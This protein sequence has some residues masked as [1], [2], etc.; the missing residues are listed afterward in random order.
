MIENLVEPVRILGVCS[1]PRRA[2]TLY[3][4]QAALKEAEKVPGVQTTLLH[5]RGKD[6]VKPCL[7]CDY[8][9]RN[10]MRCAEK[11][12]MN[13]L[14]DSLLEYDAFLF[15]TP[16]YMGT[17]NAQMKAFLD[18]L[19]PI[20]VR[21]QALTGKVGGV[22]AV[23]G[24]RAGGHEPAILDIVS[25][26]MTFGIYP[27]GG[28][29]GGNLGACVWSHDK[30]RAFDESVD[31]EG[32]RIVRALALKVAGTASWLRQARQTLGSTPAGSDSLALNPVIEAGL[33][34]EDQA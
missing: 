8:C 15:A 32:L 21:A 5:L 3:C 33:K 18:R 4:L 26:L 2:S 10:T 19:R 30:A 31:E 1:S 28:L 7:H 27:V 6:I 20:W 24:D 17:M 11:D 9:V 12:I 16:V 29:H 34:A 22:I 13:D 23:G 25:F 14:Y